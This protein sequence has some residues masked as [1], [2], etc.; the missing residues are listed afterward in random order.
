MRTVRWV[1]SHLSEKGL[2]LNCI[3]SKLAWETENSA[4]TVDTALERNKIFASF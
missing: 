1:W 3:D 2:R 4:N